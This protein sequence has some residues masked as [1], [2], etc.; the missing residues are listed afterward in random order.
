M[1]TAVLEKRYERVPLRN[2]VHKIRRLYRREFIET[3]FHYEPGQHVTFLA[4]TQNGKTTF[5]FQL[6]MYIRL[7]VIV[8]VMKP[9]DAVPAAWSR[10]LHYQEIQA[11]PPPKRYP[12]QEE[13]PGYCLWPPHTFI[14][15][16]DNPRMAG[17]FKRALEWA[18]AHGDCVVFADEV[19]GMT[20]ELGL[21]PQL[22]A[23]W[24]RGGGMGA[25]LWGATQRPTGS[26]GSG[27]PGHMYS[28][29]Q[30]LFLSKD[31]DAA[32]RKRYGEIGGVDPKLIEAIVMRLKRF[33]FLHIDKGD[34]SGGPYLSIIE[35]R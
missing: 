8:F 10:H 24:T 25:G 9:R 12:W 30:H 1:S 14:V 2:K 6:L 13:P 19:Y 3:Y 18:Y 11:W 26:Q 15:E 17:E 16:I 31:P 27:V 33:E 21:T 23:L 35:A 4:P 7:M 20:A 28:N 29:A 5:V 34:G 22:M 32:S